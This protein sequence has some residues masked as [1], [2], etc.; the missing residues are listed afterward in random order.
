MPD[1]QILT[2]T[3]PNG[4]TVLVEQMA[5]VQSAAFSLMV[6]AGAI[7]DEPGKE[8]CASLVCDWMTRGAGSRDS[9]QL[10]TDLDNLGLHRSEH[11]GSTHLSF[12]GAALSE[13]LAEALRIYADI[14]R[15][16]H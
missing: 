11:A 12:G 7:Y 1:Q 10:T 16:P 8:G 9:Q 14:V 13:N 2:R 3:Y 15:R 6:P 4:L 5:D